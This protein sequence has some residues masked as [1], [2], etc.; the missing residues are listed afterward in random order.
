MVILSFMVLGIV[1]MT[2]LGID[3]FPEVNFPFVNVTVVY[4]GAGP[5]EVET[6]VAKPIEDV[7]AGINGV[8]RV[9]S[10]STEGMGRVGIEFR[11][12]VDPQA[13][14]AEVREKVAAIRG[15]LPQDIEDPTI[16]RFDVAAL[17]IMLFAVGSAQPSDV[18]RRQVEDDLKP[19][20]EQIDGVAAVEVNGGEVREIQV[21][22]DPRRLEALQLPLSEV[23]RRLAAE[24]LDVPGGQVKRDGRSIS[25]RTKGEFQTVA[26]IESVILRSD[27]GSTVRL[28]DVG[29]VLDGYEDKTSTTRL[30]GADAVSFSVR[31]QS[32]ANTVEI[33]DRVDA[34]L[35]RLVPQ[36]PQLQI[37]SVHNDAEFIKENVRDVRTHIIFGGV[38]AV[39]IIFVFMRDWRS[40][41]ISALALPTSV[42]ATFFFMWAVG[43]TINMM[44]L[45]ALSLV[46]GILIDDA[47]VVRENI[48]RHMEHG[49]DPFTAARKGT[50]EIGL[51]VMATT[52]T[53]LAVF[54]PVGFMT[55]LVGQFFKSFALTIAF[56]VAMSLL[57]A[58][59]LDPM[60]SSRFVRYVPPEERMKTR[61]GRLLEAWGRFY[62]RIDQRYQRVLAWAIERPWQ[63]LGIAAVVFF[64]SLST[65]GLMGTEFVPVEDRGQF[66]V[67]AELPPGTSFDQSVEMV[68]G[69]E[70]KVREIPEVRQ[71]FSTVGV[72]GDPLKANLR[73]KTSRKYE[74]ERGLLE[75]KTD[76][77]QRVSTV[78]LV[79]SVVSDPEFMQGA[80]TQAPVSVFLRGDDME[81]LQ[82]LSEEVTAKIRQVPGTVDVDSTLES[83]QPEMVARVNRAMAADL[84]FDVSTVALQLRGMVEGVVPTKLREGDKEYDIRVRLAPEFRND[85]QSIARAPLYS[86]NGA[87][88]RA[89]DIASLEP[90]VGPTSI[91]REQRRRQAKVDVELSGRALGD[92]TKDIETVMT[93]VQLPPGF[94]WGFAGDVELMQESA[95]A[96]GLALLLATAFIYIVLASQFESFFEPLLIMLSLPLAVVGALLAILLTGNNLGMPPMIGMVMLM[97]LVTKNAI[98]LIDMTNQFLRE[99]RSVKEAILAAGPIRL[100]PIL[101]TTMAM[102]LGMLPSALGRGEGGEFRAPISIATIGGLITSTALTLV[103]VPV[104]FLLLHRVLERLKLWR[105]H[106]AARVPA[107]VRVA[108]MLIL[109][110]AL[111]WFLSTTTAFAQVP[112]P[113]PLPALT[114]TFDEALDRALANNEGLKVT[115]QRVRESQGRVQEAKANF[116]P[117]VN[118]NFLYTPAQRF[119]LIRVPAGIFGPDEQTFEA[120]FTRRNIMQ[121]E[122][123]QPLYTAGRLQN[124]YG[125]QASAMDASKLGLERARQE[126][127][128]Q[129][130]ETF[131]AALMNEQGVRVA[132]EQIALGTKQLSLAK[133]RFDAGTVARLDVLQA[134]VELANAKARRIQAQAAVD[135]SYQAL[136][137]V[138]SIP[139]SQPL[140]LT[141]N[142][143]ERPERLTRAALQAS[144]PSRPDLRAFAAQR[145]SAEHAI[146]L[147][148]A[149]L[150]PSL[151]LTGNLQYQDDGLDSLLK[152]DNQS[153]T[154]GVALRVPLFAAPGA[155][156]RRAVAQAQA[157]QS[158]H[159]LNAATDAAHLEVESAWTAF[160]AAD[161]VV[162]TQQKALELA[163]ESVTIA[164]TS[165]E[166]GV[167]TSAELNDAQVRLLQTEWFLM[168]AKYSRIVAAARAKAA[169]GL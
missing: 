136:R 47:V 28:R 153:Y 44:T 144:I 79:K 56:A 91:E 55:G 86:P 116:L 93:A 26:E 159:G 119:P 109:I 61:A 117:A 103:V 50:A 9:E 83:G 40:T 69:L 113:R 141:G 102:I 14:T 161:E 57:V 150:K 29:E 59:T 7:V 76:A 96:M 77:R 21:N 8:K 118:L 120:G 64:A 139:Q 114:L 13:A 16:Q 42:V 104:A 68:A 3:L 137:T 127:H 111:G 140:A 81:A 20:L 145:T 5:E 167:I 82:R 90:G 133:A 107:P 33:A 24:N 25:L 19:L 132:D 156:A 78:P 58:F 36:F 67:N 48:Y 80:P 163:R 37:R 97:G 108:G 158:E 157:R 30:N 87:L 168:Q 166:N 18:T 75:I 101:M 85:F 88:V 62:D 154:V 148:N 106:P 112:G 45:M 138:L 51:A 4:P 1:S 53:I 10:S 72:N 46:I 122:V 34:T 152:T 70:R 15:R 99:G 22:L 160:E 110:V 27:A 130:V 124:A 43:F 105:A 35:A 2:R 143:D 135:T 146:A 155:S 38:M 66:E 149:E 65:L 162:T 71:V 39:L 54:L 32:G 84:G 100:R 60:L 12:E 73:I 95:A 41:L 147:A 74:R 94:E 11:L 115:E 142:L 6:L 17:P 128:Y 134:E 151:S 121:F 92:V 123:N 125:I 49:E 63:V 126:L 23:A 165:Y 129:V 31:K 169:A 131:Y 98:L 164:Q 52:F 89:S